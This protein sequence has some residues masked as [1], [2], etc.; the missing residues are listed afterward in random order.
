MKYKENIF[1]ITD[2]YHSF[3]FIHMDR[4]KE[5]IRKILF[6]AAACSALTF[7][8]PASA[9]VEYWF[10]RHAETEGNIGVA[11]AHN[12]NPNYL[13][14]LTDLGRHQ[15]MERAQGLVNEPVISLYSSNALRTIQT[16]YYITAETDQPEPIV[17]PAI[18][19]WD[20]AVPASYSQ[21][22]VVAAMYEV[23]PLWLSGDTSAKLSVSGPE[24]ESLAD[25]VSRTVPGYQ[26]IIKQHECD[27][28]IIAIV[29]HGASI[30]WSMPY[31]ADN[32]DLTFAIT[33]GLHNT[34]IVKAVPNGNKLTVISWEGQEMDTSSLDFKKPK[35]CNKGNKPK[36]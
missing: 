18:R 5:M 13:N 30:G 4:Y 29:S 8:L 6:S 23:M 14:E 3:F 2:L 33:N 25:M 36:H 9:A 22:E 21:E 7:S 15:A 1:V 16:A 19:E 24:G 17:V 28:G 31:L 34:G 32:V 27:D 12:P 10:I 35:Q 11:N 26:K 20:P